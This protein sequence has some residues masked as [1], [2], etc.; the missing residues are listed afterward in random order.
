[1]DEDLKD[2]KARMRSLEIMTLSLIA[3]L[4]DPHLVHRLID[5]LDQQAAC[6]ERES[7]LHT[8]FRLHS[9]KDE[10]EKIAGGDVR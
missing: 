1:M 8:L 7:E 10:L 4:G 2:L 9:L 6:A 3:V 5:M